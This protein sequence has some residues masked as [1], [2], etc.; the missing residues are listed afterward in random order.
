MNIIKTFIIDCVIGFLGFQVLRSFLPTIDMSNWGEV[1]V[2]VMNVAV[3]IAVPLGC[4]VHFVK[5]VMDTFAPKAP[6]IR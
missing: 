2:L 4:V 6:T 3:P 1:A 5:T